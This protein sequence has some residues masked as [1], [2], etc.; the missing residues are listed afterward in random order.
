MFIV[1]ANGVECFQGL[2]RQQQLTKE[3][4][5]VHEPQDPYDVRSLAEQ[6]SLPRRLDPNG[7]RLVS[8]SLGPVK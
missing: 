4:D 3:E 8:L 2:K 6:T 5:S 1:G 7:Y